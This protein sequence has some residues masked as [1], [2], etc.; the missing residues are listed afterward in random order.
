MMYGLDIGGTKI[1]L[2]I[3]NNEYQ[4]E[5][6]WRVATP[7]RDYDQFISTVVGM[8]GE[9]DQKTGNQGSVGMGIPGFVDSNGSVVSANVPCINGQCVQ[10]NIA[11]ELGRPVGFEN[12]VKA[13][14]LSE[15]NGGAADGAHS[16]LGLVLGTGVAAGLCIDGKLYAGRQHVAGECGHIP[17]AASLMHK[18]KLPM[19]D[20]GC[21]GVGCVE[22]Y[23]SGPGLQWLCGVL[24]SEY[25]D[26]PGLMYGVRQG[27]SR[28][29]VVFQV[30]LNC[31]ASFLAQL[32]L[33]YDPEVIVLGGGLS[34]INEIYERVS[35]MI[36]EYLFKGVSAPRI[37]S[38]KFGDSS[39]VRGAAILGQQVFQCEQML[40]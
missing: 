7:I 9:A 10:K 11:A 15:A 25:T 26:V 18:Y 2:A 21:G 31:L 40:V 29:E 16:S 1:E 5:E 38:P 13:F 32:T 6:S 8:V 3:F 24:G 17:I 22:Q 35:P 23:L 14:A 37:M 20:C 34:K 19:R 12:D 27:E 28:A 39:G 36:E 4:V 30:Y 33:M